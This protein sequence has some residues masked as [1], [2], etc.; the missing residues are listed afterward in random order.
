[1][2]TTYFANFSKDLNRIGHSIP[3][4]TLMNILKS[5]VIRDV[6]IG[7]CFNHGLNSNKSCQYNFY[8]SLYKWTASVW[9][10]YIIAHLIPV[11]FYK[12]KEFQANPL[13]VIRRFLWGFFKSLCFIW[14]NSI[15]VSIIYCMHNG[16]R[17]Q[18]SKV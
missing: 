15:S 14:P 18:F 11:V 13:K 7:C 2:L 5:P 6:N 16:T 17:N 10:V 4:T 12:R 3:D 9:K 1:M 8:L